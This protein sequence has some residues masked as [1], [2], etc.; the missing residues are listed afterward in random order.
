MAEERKEGAE[1]GGGGN[2]EAIPSLS[3]FTPSSPFSLPPLSLTHCPTPLNLPFYLL[4]C[5]SFLPLSQ[6]ILAAR[7]SKSYFKLIAGTK[8]AEAGAGLESNGSTTSLPLLRSFSLDLLRLHPLRVRLA[9]SYPSSLL[10]NT[11]FVL[12][13]I[14]GRRVD[15]VP[16]RPE[17]MRPPAALRGLLQHIG[18]L[19]LTGAGL[20]CPLD[21][22]ML[23]G[24]VGTGTQVCF[25]SL[26]SLSFRAVFCDTAPQ[27]VSLRSHFLR[28]QLLS[29]N[30]SP[31]A[32][33]QQQKEEEEEEE[34]E[35]GQS[36]EAL[37]HGTKALRILMG[38]LGAR[39][40]NMK[41]KAVLMH[42]QTQLRRV[43]EALTGSA[44]DVQASSSSSSSS[45]PSVSSASALQ[46][47]DIQFESAAWFTSA[48]AEAVR[49]KPLRVPA[50][51]AAEGRPTA[52][53]ATSSA[54]S[55]EKEQ[56]CESEPATSVPLLL[57]LPSLHSL[58]LHVLS[59]FPLSFP[60]S[61]SS[62]SSSC[63][64]LSILLPWLSFS[65]PMLERL[66]LNVPGDREMGANGVTQQQQQQL[67][68]FPSLATLQIDADNP[69][70]LL[71]A[72]LFRAISPLPLP[73][74][75]SSS[76]LSPSI[77]LPSS[78][79]ALHCTLRRPSW[80]PSVRSALAALN[81]RL[82]GF[83]LSITHRSHLFTLPSTLSSLSHLRSLSLICKP[84]AARVLFRLLRPPSS[85]VDLQISFI[86]EEEEDEEVNVDDEG[87][88]NQ[89]EEHGIKQA[90]DDS[91]EFQLTPSALDAQ[92]GLIEG[93]L[94]SSVS[95]P[96][97]NRVESMRLGQEGLGVNEG[98]RDGPCV[99]LGVLSS[100]RSLRSFR[101]SHAQARLGDEEF[102]ALC[103][104]LPALTSIHIEAS[105]HLTPQALSALSSARRPCRNAPLTLLRIIGCPL[106]ASSSDSSTPETEAE[107]VRHIAQ[108]SQLQELQLDEL[109]MSSLQLLATQLRS[110]LRCLTL[111]RLIRDCAQGSS[112]QSSRSRLRGSAASKLTRVAGPEVRFRT[113]TA[114]SE[115]HRAHR[116][117]HEALQQQWREWTSPYERIALV[118][119]EAASEGESQ[120]FAAM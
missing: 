87:E 93:E 100:L 44:A 47:L 95:A 112:P 83:T 41:I 16:T 10:F 37:T 103:I 50:A 60:P 54:T 39:L 109:R 73:S 6:I 66:E 82:T 1:A 25:P 85:L 11:Q 77:D 114:E 105:P 29:I 56:S 9:S 8:N 3:I 70:P 110:S 22:L 80:T 40:K 69:A 97:Y 64:P 62:S 81:T 111:T 19:D 117:A 42:P 75:S 27:W 23:A 78:L 65:L 74:S 20:L 52:A 84:S 118:I 7:L 94:I 26:H 12:A 58:I 90:E 35:G 48:A 88:D 34:E 67:Q 53:A 68:A 101:F 106:F 31:L 45:S 99:S 36:T 55:A 14:T 33:Q 38:A 17:L 63:S 15:L 32:F 115:G 79:P 5:F 108:L 51:A 76:S 13:T 4:L 98:S 107:F 86:P 120:G 72:A 24:R 43:M 21:M 30:S 89:N 113:P 119:L 59:P 116:L 46:H 61:S 28:K 49:S 18:A 102:T 96:R 2:D 91:D 104:D 71:T 57:P 92:C